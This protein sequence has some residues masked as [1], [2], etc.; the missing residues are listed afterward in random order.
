VITNRTS[1]KLKLCQ[2]YI[3]DNKDKMVSLMPEDRISF[4]WTNADRDKRV[5]FLAD[6]YH[7]WSADFTLH[8]A[9]VMSVQNL[10]TKGDKRFFKVTKKNL[11]GSVFIIIEDLVHPPYLIDNKCS[12]L[13]ASCMQKGEINPTMITDVAPLA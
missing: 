2:S 6:S 4:S 9:G 11:Y 1:A 12:E 8:D 13:F 5:K 7:Y 10:N 3:V